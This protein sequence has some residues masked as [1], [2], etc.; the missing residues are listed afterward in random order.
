VTSDI[1]SRYR[2]NNLGSS[3]LYWYSLRFIIAVPLGEAIAAF[4]GGAGASAGAPATLVAGPV[5]AFVLSMFSLPRIQSMLSA[6]AVKTYNLPVTTDAT[7]DDV[8]IQL[9][10]IDQDIADVLAAESVNTI[11]AIAAA[12]PVMLSGRTAIPFNLVLEYID[13]ALLWKFVGSKLL[14]MRE[15]GWAGASHVLN[16]ADRWAEQQAQFQRAVAVAAASCEAR[17]TALEDAQRQVDDAAAKVTEALAADDPLRAALL[18]AKA[19]VVRCQSA[20]D[21]ADQAQKAAA[22][23]LLDAQ[24][25]IATF[26]NDLADQAK[27]KVSGLECVEASITTNDYARFI[28]RLMLVGATSSARADA[29]ADGTAIPLHPGPR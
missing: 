29:T 10:G 2:L 18:D 26:Y 11:A 19:A 28:R 17:K 21:S 1:I 3:N 25:V 14:I 9:P 23:S 5:L 12:D 4:A 8:V 20:C 6:L 13:C 16:T 7:K 27:T 24:N 15:F 22:A